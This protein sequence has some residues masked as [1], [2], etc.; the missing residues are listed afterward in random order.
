MPRSFP[1]DPA[2]A[3]LVLTAPD[4]YITDFCNGLCAYHTSAQFGSD[5]LAYTFVGNPTLQCP[6]FCTYQY[7]DPT[8]T[9]ANGDLGADSVSD[10]IGHELAEL[11]TN[12][13]HGPNDKA[14]WVV[15]K[16]Q[17][18]NADLCEWMYGPVNYEKDG[19]V[20]NVRGANGTKYLLQL[21]FNVRAR[22]CALQGDGTTMQTPAMAH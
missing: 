9:G 3:Y 14:G 2:G 15:A 18:E 21:N 7:F 11:V 17:I 4:V 20:W 16:S 12:P 13:L 1:S 22:A 10:K 5:K 19:G 6:R 8:F